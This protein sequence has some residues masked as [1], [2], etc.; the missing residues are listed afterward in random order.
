M[1]IEY[2]LGFRGRIK[3][4]TLR[5]L[6]RVRP[7]TMSQRIRYGLVDRPAYAYC[8]YHAADLAARLGISKIS[9]LEFGVAGGN[10][11]VALER[12]AAG[13][14]AE[15]KLPVDFEIYGFD[16]GQ[17][18]PPPEGAEDL[19]YWFRESQYHMDESGLRERLTEASLEIGN[20]RDTVPAFLARG[21]AAPIGAVLIDVDYW[22][23]TIDCLRIFD[24]EEI[25]ARFLPRVHVYLD[26]ILGQQLEMYGPFNGMLKAVN[27]FNDTHDDK[28]IHLN[29]NLLTHGHL[30]YRYQIYYAH[31]FQH[32]DYATYIGGQSQSEMEE[33]LRLR[34]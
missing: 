26:D 30:E 3:R 9:I 20:V 16:T 8:M 4:E 24:C 19:P 22:S 12:I 11:L 34:F 2:P 7:I 18:M 31:L 21:T 28:K 17:G 1:L 27:D 25:A 5:L 13:M 6:D 10:G 14:R 29:Q 15:R 23:S 33:R 32:P